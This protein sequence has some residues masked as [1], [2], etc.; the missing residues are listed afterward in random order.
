MGLWAARRL[1]ACGACLFL[2]F[3]GSLLADDFRITI[4]PEEKKPW[5]SLD[6]GRSGDSVE[7]TNLPEALPFSPATI[8]GG[9][10]STDDGNEL[11]GLKALIRSRQDAVEN[12]LAAR[13]TGSLQEEFQAAERLCEIE[14]RI[15]QRADEF[16]E[17]ERDEL[18]GLR[19]QHLGLLTWLADRY[20]STDLGHC[21]TVWQETVQQL[22]ALHGA[23]H[24]T[25]RTAVWELHRVQ[26]TLRLDKP[27]RAELTEAQR[28]HEQVG[29]LQKQGR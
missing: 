18:D 26:T 15:L 7:G 16:P 13:R 19:D 5:V 17:H 24:W 10:S 29:I 12:V 14:R 22:T 1:G 2:V 21:E 28:L 3:A 4:K 27:Q 20:E 9:N 8:A 23:G 11:D 25:T 6:E